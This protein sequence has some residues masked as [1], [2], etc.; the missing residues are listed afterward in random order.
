MARYNV[1]SRAKVCTSKS[2]KCRKGMKDG[3]RV[4][5]LNGCCRS[6]YYRDLS[7]VPIDVAINPKYVLDKGRFEQM[8][9]ASKKVQ[10]PEGIT[11]RFIALT[12]CRLDESSR[13]T[14]NDLK[15]KKGPLSSVS[16]TNIRKFGRP[17]REVHLHN[18]DEFT[19]ELR[20]WVK[21]MSRNKPL[22][23]VVRR[24]LRRVFERILKPIKPDCTNV[25]HILRHTRANQLIVMG[26]KWSEVRQQL[27][28]PN[29]EMEKRY[30]PAD[31]NHIAK[32]LGKLV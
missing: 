12:G 8:W 28:W 2:H 26:L 17:S 29:L 14:P 1:A 3:C 20:A 6:K 23:P 10:N 31:E 7:L 11:I 25:A 4:S 15:W 13:I 19:K 5:C 18:A 16:I 9:K 27:D 22:F 30:V 32:V 24:T 21:G